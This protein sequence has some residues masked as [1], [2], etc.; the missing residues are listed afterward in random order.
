M[1][2]SSLNWAKRSSAIQCCQRHHYQPKSGPAVAESHS[3]SNLS[4]TLGGSTEPKP[5]SPVPLQRSSWRILQLQLTGQIFT[6]N[7]FEYGS[8]TR[9][10]M[11]FFL[12]LLFFTE[13]HWWSIYFAEILDDNHIAYTQH[14]YTIHTLRIFINLSCSQTYWESFIMLWFQ[15]IGKILFKII[16]YYC[17]IKYNSLYLIFDDYCNWQRRIQGNAENFLNQP[18]RKLLFFFLFFFLIK[19]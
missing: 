15:N 1:P 3:A 17:S 18:R 9:W 11:K 5:S 19:N 7:C 2:D 8:G 10:I 12:F 6:H 16:E 4:L 13:H 14:T